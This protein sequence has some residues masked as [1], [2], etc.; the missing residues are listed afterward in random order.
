MRTSKT[1]RE[2][3]G[4]FTCTNILGGFTEGIMR[5]DPSPVIRVGTTYYVWYSRGTVTFHGYTATI[6]YATSKD[7]YD[8]IEQGQ[9]LGRGTVGA[10]DEHAVFTPSILVHEDRYYLSYTAVPEPFYNGAPGQPGITPTAIGL[11]VAKSPDGP[12]QRVGTEPILT[13]SADPQQFDSLRI[14]D[15][16]FVLREG[17]IWMYYKGRGIGRTPAQTKMGLAIADQPEGPYQRVPESPVVDGGHEVC[18]WPTDGG[19]ASM[20]SK[21]GP[22]GNTLQFAADGRHFTK[23]ADITPPMAPGPFRADHFENNADMQLT[24]GVCM[25]EENGWPWLQRFDRCYVH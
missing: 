22:Q 8:W 1:T 17:R 14:D 19:I 21:V 24:W 18:V 13:P 12:W 16:C 11:A 23:V 3:I 15:T 7:G 20:H 9:A 5:R 10:F 4:N 2:P 6:W 25:R